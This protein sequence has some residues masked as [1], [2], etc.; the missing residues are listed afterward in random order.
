M[1]LVLWML[2]L[3][4]ETL[5]GTYYFDTTNGFGRTF[6]GVGGISGGGVS[7]IYLNLA[8]IKY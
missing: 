3:V 7:I 5:C 2:L 6:D 1:E 4:K 8:N